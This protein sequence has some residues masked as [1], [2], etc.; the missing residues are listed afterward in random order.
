MGAV[1]DE[2]DKELVKDFISFRDK[3]LPS[4][5]L[6]TEVVNYPSWKHLE[7][8]VGLGGSNLRVQRNAKTSRLR[9]NTREKWRERI[10]E[11]YGIDLYPENYPEQAVY[12]FVEFPLNLSGIDTPPLG[13][14]PVGL[15]PS[16]S[17]VVRPYA[18]QIT[19]VLLN[20]VEKIN[21]NTFVPPESQRWRN[22]EYPEG[23]LLMDFD[24]PE[25]KIVDSATIHMT[26][27]FGWVGPTSSISKTPF[28]IQRKR[29]QIVLK[30]FY[31]LFQNPVS[32]QRGLALEFTGANYASEDDYNLSFFSK[33]IRL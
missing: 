4:G 24:S 20:L 33:I 19:V 6:A 12:I 22:S 27:V 30:E 3:K 9:L 11:V 8:E 28:D 25:I 15:T 14:Y 23:V 10:I 7:R 18:D 17:L 1:I 21:Y 26:F 5:I 31:P 29:Q 16:Q 2:I 32:L 13:P